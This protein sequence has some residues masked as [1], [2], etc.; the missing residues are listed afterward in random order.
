MALS[1][2]YSVFL[3]SFFL[4]AALFLYP[5][6]EKKNKHCTN[7]SLFP[8]IHPIQP[9]TGT[10]IHVPC[11]FLDSTI[12]RSYT[13]KPPLPLP[14]PRASVIRFQIAYVQKCNSCSYILHP[15]A[16][17]THARIQVGPPY[18]VTT[19]Y[20]DYTYIDM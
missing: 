5:T 19:T 16:Q 7:I 12:S 17:D 11:P 1:V 14:L 4:A 15:F 18:P 20:T 13:T 8:Y 9:S 3:S 2:L 10:R 6:A